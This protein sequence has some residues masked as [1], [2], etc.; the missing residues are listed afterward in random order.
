MPFLKSAVDKCKAVFVNFFAKADLWICNIL[1]C[2]KYAI[3]PFANIATT[4][5]RDTSILL[6]II[7]NWIYYIFFYDVQNVPESDKT[8]NNNAYNAFN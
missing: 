1:E 3:A 2:C 7:E 8:R 4:I 5:A 6:T